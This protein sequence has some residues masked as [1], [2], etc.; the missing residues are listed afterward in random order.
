MITGIPRVQDKGKTL[1]MV[2][3]AID[4]YDN[5][6]FVEVHSTVDI[7]GI[8]GIN[9]YTKEEMRDYVGKMVR[10]KLRRQLVLID[11]INSVFPARLWK[12]E[13]QTE[14]LLGLWQDYKMCNQVIYTT[15]I[16]VTVDKIIRDTTMG[17]RLMFP[18]YRK[19]YDD[20]IAVISD[21]RYMKR[22]IRRFVNVSKYFTRYDR[23][24]PV[25]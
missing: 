20:L 4:L 3:M 9:V 13:E 11:E 15:H 12:R 8:N 6:G 25:V 24:S 17:G 22:R 1:L 16:G 5:Y 14:T 21:F 18:E 23:W 10:D 2:M 19:G 7:K